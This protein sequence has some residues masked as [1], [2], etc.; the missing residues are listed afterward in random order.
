V[1]GEIKL[2]HSSCKP[3]SASLCSSDKMN[4]GDAVILFMAMMVAISGE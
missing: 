4:T 3:F 1:G 2:V